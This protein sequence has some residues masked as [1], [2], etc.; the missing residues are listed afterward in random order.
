VS[1]KGRQDRGR[2]GA[3]GWSAVGKPRIETG[4]GIRGGGKC[5]NLQFAQGVVTYLSI[6]FIDFR[7]KGGRLKKKEEGRGRE[8]GG[9]GGF[10][11]SVFFW[12]K[13]MVAMGDLLLRPD[14]RTNCSRKVDTPIKLWAER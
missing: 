14:E 7:K 9:R 2:K 11:E 5:N 6:R 1:Y 10:R 8:E 12:W 3:S 4:E 13:V